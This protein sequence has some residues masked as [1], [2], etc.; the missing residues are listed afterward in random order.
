[1]IP[2]HNCEW[3]TRNCVIIKINSECEVIIAI[4]KKAP[5]EKLNN[6]RKIV[7]KYCIKS[8]R[9]IQ[10]ISDGEKK[11]REYRK[12]QRTFKKIKKGK[13]WLK[14]QKTKRIKKKH[15]KIYLK[16]INKK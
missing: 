15:K 16:R 4:I 3:Y 13:I 7:K 12:M 5:N 8:S 6:S 11:K 10:R 9:L 1:M 14:R 2:H